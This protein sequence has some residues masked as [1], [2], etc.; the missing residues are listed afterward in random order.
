MRNTRCLLNGAASSSGF[1][2]ISA[3]LSTVATWVTA[4]TP[5]ATYSRTLRWR[6]AM[7]RERLVTLRSLA[8]SLNRA[9]IVYLEH[10]GCRLPEAQITYD[11]AHVGDLSGGLRGRHDLRLGGRERDAL[12][13][14][15]G[16]RDRSTGE[17]HNEPRGRVGHVPVRVNVSFERRTTGA[18]EGDAAVQRANEVVEAP[19]G[20]GQRIDSG[21]G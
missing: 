17:Q 7:W 2:K 18:V 13:A 5:S 21:E 8:S 16:V 9:G 4:I 11:L 14:L 3:A 1:V 10:G 19:M 20:G 12:L 6:R 15:A